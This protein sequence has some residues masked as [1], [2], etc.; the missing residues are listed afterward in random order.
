[1]PAY[2][3]AYS[4][5]FNPKNI[6]KYKGKIPITYRSGLEYRLMMCLDLSPRILQ[7]GSESVVVNYTDPTRPTLS[8]MPSIH[9]YFI[10]FYFITKDKNTGQNKKYYVEVKLLTE[11]MHPVRGNKKMKTYEN[12]SITYARNVS[13]WRAAIVHARKMGGEFKVF[14]EKDIGTMTPMFLNK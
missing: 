1:M 7:W 10:D 9:R 13:K 3:K 6:D 12:E 11:T 4:G 14:T 2:R 8:G 5:Y